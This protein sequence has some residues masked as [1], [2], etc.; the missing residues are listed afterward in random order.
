VEEK[1]NFNEET[2]L[3]CVVGRRTEEADAEEAKEQESKG[4]SVCC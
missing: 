2:L 4:K 3:R 1:L